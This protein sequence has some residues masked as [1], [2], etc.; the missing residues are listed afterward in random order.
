MLC[1]EAATSGLF[2]YGLAAG[3]LSEPEGSSK[4]SERHNTA[5]TYTDHR[6]VWGK[7]TGSLVMGVGCATGNPED[8]GSLRNRNR[9]KVR[10]SEQLGWRF[11]GTGKCGGVRHTLYG[12]VP[13]CYCMT[14]YGYDSGMRAT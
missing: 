12:S 3:E 11:R 14:R 7:L 6:H 10:V 1:P 2:V 9:Y 8:S 13:V 5:P 4:M